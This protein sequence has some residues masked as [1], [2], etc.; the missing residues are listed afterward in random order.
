[1]READQIDSFLAGLGFGV[2]LTVMAILVFAKA[3][4]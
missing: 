1:M 2:V 3:F 4:G